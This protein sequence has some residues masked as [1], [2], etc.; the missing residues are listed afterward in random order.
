M[1]KKLITMAFAMMMAVSISACGG[2][3]EKN[4]TTERVTTGATEEGTTEATSETT[5]EAVKEDEKES[6]KTDETE[7]ESTEEQTTASTTSTNNQDKA[8][9]TTAKKEETSAG[10][11]GSSSSNKGTSTSNKGT[12][13]SDKNTSNSGKNTGNSNKNTGSSDK[14]TGNSDKNT[15][16]SDK[17][18]GGSDKNNGNSKPSKPSKPSTEE[19]AEEVSLTEIVNAVKKAYGDSYLPNMSIEADVLAEQYGIKKNM[20]EEVIAEGPMLSF[21]ID[22]FIAVKAKDGKVDAVKSAMESYK[23]Y[24]VEESLQY[25][26]NAA[27][28]PAIQVYSFD[29]YVFFSM[30]VTPSEDNAETEEEIL[31]AAKTQNQIAY[32]TI[33]KFFQ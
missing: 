18:T 13:T 14:N 19:P 9:A 8:S 5:T 30:L 7:K 12:S 22:T 21:Q 33:A 26:M 6:D 2:G 23:D 15:G 16:N 4:T 24:L 20:Y 10:N 28:L 29:N 32:D 25:P 17:N 11:T 27:K 1:R 31:E 3:S